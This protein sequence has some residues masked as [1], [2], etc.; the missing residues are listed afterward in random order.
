MHCDKEFKESA[1]ERF[2][3]DPSL[4]TEER[5]TDR[6]SERRRER[7]RE[8]GREREGERERG[9]EGE[10]EE[11]DRAKGSTAL[12]GLPPLWQF[13]VSCRIPTHWKLRNTE[14]AQKGYGFEIK[15]TLG[16]DGVPCVA[17]PREN[18]PFPRPGCPLV[19]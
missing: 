14:E 11:K 19:R 4:T 17:P 13:S 9:G 3:P 15:R 7:E 18:K 2:H 16:G 1:E 12:I 8:G 5:E 10:E 6:E